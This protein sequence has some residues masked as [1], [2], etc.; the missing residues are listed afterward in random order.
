[1]YSIVSLV[2]NKVTEL[3]FQYILRVLPFNMFR[4]TLDFT[5]I[6]LEIRDITVLVYC[7]FFTFLKQT[8]S[9]LDLLSTF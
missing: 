4:G 1:M 8:E 5:H 2:K 7:L 6:S 3:D 9:S